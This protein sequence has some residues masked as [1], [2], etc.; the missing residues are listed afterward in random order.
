MHVL[1]AS[2]RVNL[3]AAAAGGTP[4]ELSDDE[5]DAWVDVS[6]EILGRLSAHLLSRD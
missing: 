5:F 4:H 2:A 3:E 1:E 6:D